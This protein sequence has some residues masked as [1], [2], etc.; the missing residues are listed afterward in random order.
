MIVSCR[1]RTGWGRRAGV[2]IALSAL[3]G[4][5]IG[6]AAQASG[7]RRGRWKKR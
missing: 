3:D 1:W 5:R 6:I 7:W 4:G 2:E